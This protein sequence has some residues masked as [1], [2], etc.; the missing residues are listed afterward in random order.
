MIIGGRAL[1]GTTIDLYHYAGILRPKKTV[2]NLFED[3]E[4]FFPLVLN[5]PSIEA[6][7]YGD[8]NR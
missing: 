1:H 2:S 8:C 7:N 6:K 4:T 5:D 3:L